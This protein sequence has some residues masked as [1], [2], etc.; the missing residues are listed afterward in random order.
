MQTRKPVVAVAGASGYIG[1]NLLDCLKG[2]AHVIALSR[3]GGRR[4]ST[5]DVTWRSCDLFSMK[6]AE[7]GL[8]GADIAVYLVHS[9]LKSAKLTQG[10]FEDMDVIL[11][12][13]F[14]QAAKK[15]GVQQII[16][17][18]GIVPEEDET[19]LSRH[20]KSR[21]EVERVLRDYG[22]PVTALRAGLIVGPKGSSFPILSKL[23]K[24][25]PVMVLPKW[26]KTR[27]QPVALKDVLRGLTA[28][29]LDTELEDRSIDI[30][31]PDV[32]TYRTMMKAT[33][34]VMGKNPK[35]IGV[36]FFTLT[37]SR[38]WLRLVTN[39][40]KEMVYPLV[41]SLRHAMVIQPGHYVEGVSDGQTPFREAARIALD[42]E[43]CSG[44]QKRAGSLLPNFGPLKQDV[45][46]V[47]RI[48][49]PGGWTADEAARYYVRWLET[50]LN[51][52]VHTAADN[53]L[54]CKIGF[55][56]DHTLLEL[57]Y[58]GERSTEDRALYYI[59]G[60]LLTDTQHNERGRMEFRKIPGADEAI[61]AIHDYLPSLPWFVYYFTQAFM[62]SFV[63]GA[64][65][66]HMN[67]LS[68]SEEDRQYVCALT[69][70][71][72]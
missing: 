39:T 7:K 71:D 54:N 3:S 36:P 45:R 53:E 58:S 61:I 12:D 28:V 40:P 18:G 67:R 30:G 41:E 51:P 21:L 68:V 19:H 38:L 48:R 6:D 32:M 34:E 1:H 64:F 14:A 35:M 22:V 11:A 60:G 44:K 46:S 29:I 17:L 56:G 31:G 10:T 59:T 37:L 43:R 16:Y 8:E 69:V 72:M 27:T 25:L 66:R 50:F 15:Q 2:K 55:L 33:A 5:E 62:H 52:W 24:R 9:M 42:E 47:Q 57:S 63:M 20:L 13:N 23:V 70:K 4:Q 65:R 26:T 49:L